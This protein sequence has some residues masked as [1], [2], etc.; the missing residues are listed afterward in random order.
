MPKKAADLAQFQVRK[1]EPR[2][3]TAREEATPEAE[4]PRVQKGFRIRRD[5]AR[6]LGQLKLDLGRSEQDLVAEALNLLFEK[7]N[8]PQIA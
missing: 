4:A 5:A 7:Y 6:E 8:R 1:P 3:G 2:A